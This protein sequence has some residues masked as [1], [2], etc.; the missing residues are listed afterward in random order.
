[1]KNEP[2]LTAAAV[3][4]VAVAI[5]GLLVAFGAPI[6]DEQQTAILAVVGVVVPLASAL[7]ARSKVTPVAKDLP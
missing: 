6:S 2:V 7:Y 1:M 4:P 3:T 5:L